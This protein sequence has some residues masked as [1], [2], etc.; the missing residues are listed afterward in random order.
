MVPK[1]VAL[2]HHQALTHSSAVWAGLG[3][4]GASLLH[5]VSWGWFQALCSLTPLMTHLTWAMIW[6]FHWS[7]SI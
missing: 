4:N 6:D 5:T 2:K 3:G 7:V 1:L